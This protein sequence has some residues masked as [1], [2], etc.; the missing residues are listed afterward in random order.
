VYVVSST[1]E[2]VARN[3][4]YSAVYGHDGR[5]LARAHEW[6]TVVTAEV[7]LDARTHWN[8]L[9]DFKAQIPRHRPAVVGER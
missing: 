4:M 7:D 3:W 9:G 2:D 8:C 1:Y 5:T 6:G